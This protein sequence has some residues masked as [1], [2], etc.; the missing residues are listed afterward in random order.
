MQ[1]RLLDILRCPLC[2]GCFRLEPNAY[3][4][5]RKEVLTGKLVCPCSA[6]PIVAGIPYLRAGTRAEAVLDLLESGAGEK[7]LFRLLGLRKAEQGKFRE[8]ARDP[9]QWTFRNVLSLLGPEAESMYFLYRFSDPNYL[10]GRAALQ[11][12]G[13]DPRCWSGLVLDLGGGPGHFSRMLCRLSRGRDVILVEREF[14]KIWL[15]RQFL[16]PACQPLC[17]TAQLPLPFA[18][19]LFSLVFCSDAFQYIRAKRLLAGEML[20]LLA[21]DGLILL[22]HLH[23]ALCEVNYSAGWPLCPGEYR[24]LFAA[25]PTQLFKESALLDALCAGRPLDLA[26]D[27]ADHE[28]AGELGLVLAAT[29][30]TDRFRVYPK[31]AEASPECAWAVNPLYARELSEHPSV[32]KLSFPS[33]EYESGCAACRR[34]LPERVTLSEGDLENLGRGRLAGRLREYAERSV[35]LDLPAGY[36]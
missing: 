33:P 10:C 36:W 32:W 5:V 28:L 35:L 2:G 8:Y 11:A 26:T 19:G 17:A 14:W 4:E 21:P 30:L 13:R 9:Q 7:A 31:T 6:Y 29:R 15:A 34:Y 18:P 23:N 25:L 3:L 12:F 24:R 22:H 27:S 16:A 1:S 20:Q